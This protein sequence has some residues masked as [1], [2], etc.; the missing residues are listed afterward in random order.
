MPDVRPPM[1]ARPSI[2]V[3]QAVSPDEVG[4]APR[5]FVK[6]EVPTVM[7]FIP[8]V[9]GVSHS[10]AEFTK[11]EDLVSGLH[12][13]TEVVRRLASGALAE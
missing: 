5:V 2:S 10:L 11:D 12:H 4:A 8:S 1:S 7:L 13:L 6:D 3:G 9:D